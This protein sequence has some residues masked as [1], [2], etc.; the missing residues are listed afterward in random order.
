MIG[1]RPQL[2]FIL[3]HAIEA[4][5]SR[6]VLVMLQGEYAKRQRDEEIDGQTLCCLLS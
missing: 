4:V 5:V 3:A 2:H 1:Q 6:P